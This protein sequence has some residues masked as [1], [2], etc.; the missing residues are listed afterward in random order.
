MKKYAMLVVAIVVSLVVTTAFAF[1][2]ISKGDYTIAIRPRICQIL[3]EPTFTKRGLCAATMKA[4]T[5]TADFSVYQESLRI[6]GGWTPSSYRWNG[7]SYFGR[8][9]TMGLTSEINLLPLGVSDDGFMEEDVYLPGSSQP[10]IYIA[11]E[12]HWW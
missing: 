7:M 1:E 11:Y 9:T 6:G 12:V 5:F 8:G 3:T 2:K 4:G 10:D